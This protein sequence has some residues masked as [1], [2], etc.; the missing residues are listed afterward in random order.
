MVERSL[1]VVL[2]LQRDDLGV[3]AGLDVDA[4]Y[5]D[6]IRVFLVPRPDG[7]LAGEGKGASGL[8]YEGLAAD[9]HGLR[10]AVAHVDVEA[11]LF[12]REVLGLPHE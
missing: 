8:V 12:D 9:P 11:H 1:D 3:R 5:V 10:G 2:L 6:Q 7:D 4:V